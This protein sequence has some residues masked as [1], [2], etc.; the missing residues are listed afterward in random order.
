MPHSKKTR[1]GRSHLMK[2]YVDWIERHGIRV[3]AIP[4]DTHDHEEY[5]ACI[6]GLLIPGGDTPYVLRCRAFM[7]SVRRFLELSLSSA[8]PFPIWGT[9][10]GM[11]ALMAAMGNIHSFGSFPA[12]GL[13]PI[14]IT[15]EG[16]RSR[17]IREL[18]ASQR[19]ILE[20]TESTAQN[21][22]YGISVEDFMSNASLRRFFT[23]VAVAVAE[24]VQERRTYVAAI[25]GRGGFPVFGVM[26]HPERSPHDPFATVFIRQ[27]KESGRRPSPHGMIP[28]FSAPIHR[29]IQYPE[30]SDRSCFF[31]P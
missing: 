21:H 26:W 20:Q 22:E 4:F 25:E 11:E 16:R 24:R 7:R 31:Y 1:W 10:F 28:P 18:T 19:R 5:V 6:Q 13:T 9:C 30:H 8:H 29:C 12:H 17:M 3:V 27:I 15:A 23:V 14:Q 2:D